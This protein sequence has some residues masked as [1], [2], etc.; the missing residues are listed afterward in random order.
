MLCPSLSPFVFLGLVSLASGRVL[1]AR[2]GDVAVL[3]RWKPHD[4]VAVLQERASAG[5]HGELEL[6]FKPWLNV[7]GGCFPYAA[8]D[9]DGNH[10]MGLRPTGD[11][12]G[13]CGDAD[14]G[15][16]YARVGTSSGRTGIVYSWYQPKIQTDSESHKHSYSSIVVWVHSDKC[17]A[18][19]DDHRVV[20]V[21]YSNGKDTYD[22]ALSPGTLYAAGSTAGNTH[23]V[24]GHDGQVN[25]FPSRN[26]AEHALYPPLIDWDRL[27]PLAT[28]QLNGM[29]YQHA[30]CPFNDGNI[31]AS[32]DAAFN[33]DFYADL[34]A[35]RDDCEA[36][37]STPAPL[38][39]ATEVDLECMKQGPASSPSTCPFSLVQDDGTTLDE[40]DAEAILRHMTAQTFLRYV[41]GDRAALTDTCVFYTKGVTRAGAAT[42][43]SALATDWA[44]RESQKPRYTIWNLFPNAFDASIHKGVRDFYAMFTPGSWLDPI[45]KKQ[46]EF[47][48]TQPSG[49]VPPSIRYFQQMSESM[50]EACFGKIIILTE[51]PKELALY[52]PGKKY[53]DIRFNNIF[54]SHER[55]VLQRKVKAGEARLYAL[56]A[57]T[58]E[59]WEIVDV[60]TFQLG[61]STKFRRDLESAYQ[62][63][64][65]FEQSQV[66][67][68]DNVCPRSGLASQPPGQDWFGS[69]GIAV[70]RAVAEEAALAFNEAASGRLTT[71]AFAALANKF[72]E[73]TG[74][75]TSTVTERQMFEWE[76]EKLANLSAAKE[77]LWEKAESLKQKK[78][79]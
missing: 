51:T 21:S 9:K 3:D 12:D 49:V 60:D 59:A 18:T 39:T 74:N 16:L 66:Q 4:Q 20:G 65:T 30:R 29:Q 64:G 71:E 22:T 56:D 67:A 15:Q 45:R 62:I 50:A 28:E 25:V 1:S 11:D 7:G 69:Y 41:K 38:G 78:E 26:G 10:G 34:K 72:N 27:P 37:T 55:P 6:R 75:E 53:Q 73:Q 13:D 42:G 14:K 23:P 77:M 24:V 19:A 63:L 54:W 68:R 40:T 5:V 32:L 57:N 8:V 44:C 17:D 31:Q 48:K 58:K 70:N 79:I 35:K 52:E 36:E 2:G 33:A 61:P 47:E 46:Q 76:A 43:L